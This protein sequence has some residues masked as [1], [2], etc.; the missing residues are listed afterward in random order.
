MPLA[1]I[2]VVSLFCG[3]GETDLGFRRSGFA[4]ILAI[5]D[6]QS[7]ADSYNWNH[8]GQVAIKVDITELS[9][10]EFIEL[11]KRAAPGV[12]PRGVI[13]GPPCQSFSFGNVRKK[14]RDPRAWLGQ[15]YARV[16]KA[17]NDAFQLDFFVFENVLGLKSRRHKRPLNLIFRS[18]ERAGFTLF[19][20]ELDASTASACLR[21]GIS[22]SSD[23]IPPM[24]SV[25]EHRSQ[26]RSWRSRCKSA[27]PVP[28]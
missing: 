15:E 4:P 23:K 6:N 20:E 10:A 24:P 19:E 26:W 7:A 16:L 12:V 1:P 8:T 21:N 3:P 9:T 13:G 5:D 11:V 27:T 17:L 2:P 14:R 22:Q 28:R 25:L 18:L